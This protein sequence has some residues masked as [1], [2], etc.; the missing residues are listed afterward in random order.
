MTVTEAAPPPP[1]A[2]KHAGDCHRA[3]QRKEAH[4][5]QQSHLA[6]LWGRLRLA[7]FVLV[8]VLLHPLLLSRLLPSR[9]LIFCCLWGA[10]L[11][12]VVV[13][14]LAS[15]FVRLVLFSAASTSGLRAGTSL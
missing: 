8:L 15:V 3:A 2:H 14:V 6:M 4:K 10:M 11:P 13:F 1:A 7:S 5:G 9:R 12:R